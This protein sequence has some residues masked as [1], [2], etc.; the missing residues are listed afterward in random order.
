MLDICPAN[1]AH[2]LPDADIKIEKSL[3]ILCHLLCRDFLGLQ[4]TP[5]SCSVSN[6]FLYKCNIQMMMILE[7]CEY[8]TL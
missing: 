1:T 2:H 6:P 7:A 4:F 5:L 8:Q 3:A